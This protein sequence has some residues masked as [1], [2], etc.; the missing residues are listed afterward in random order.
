MPAED[1]GF[2]ESLKRLDRVVSA[3]EGGELGL[4]EA[5]SRYEEGVRL[6]GRCKSLLDAAERRVALVTAVD[7]DGVAQTTPFDAPAGA[8]AE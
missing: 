8:S 5:L 1:P 3:L 6:L 7:D 4:D 2:E